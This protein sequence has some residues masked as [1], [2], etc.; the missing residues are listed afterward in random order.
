[1]VQY[2]QVKSDV[3][4]AFQ[5]ETDRMLADA[6]E[7][8]GKDSVTTVIDKIDINAAFGESGLK[9]PNKNFAEFAKQ[10]T[11]KHDQEL[12]RTSARQSSSIST[13]QCGQ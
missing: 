3:Q 1:V 11:K 7:V 2:N 9:T 10:P 8:A 13:S 12:S 5:V 6:G 4:H